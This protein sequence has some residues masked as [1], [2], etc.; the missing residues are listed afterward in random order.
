[1]LNGRPL[2]SAHPEL[3]GSDRLPFFLT[4]DTWRSVIMA[5]FDSRD[6]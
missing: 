3:P 2:R 6:Y 1:M 5:L 4:G